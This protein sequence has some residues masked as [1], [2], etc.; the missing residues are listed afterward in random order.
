MAT[1]TSDQGYSR[2]LAISPD[3]SWLATGGSYKVQVWSIEGVCR[4]TLPGRWVPL[5]AAAV[6]PGRVL[7]GHRE[8]HD[9][10]DLGR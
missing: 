2:A 1:I 3:G 10:A 5:H 9:G 6:P 7:A 8:R 4:A